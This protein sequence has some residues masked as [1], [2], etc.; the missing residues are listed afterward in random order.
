M[1]YVRI[2]EG[3]WDWSHLGGGF[4]HFY[5]H[6]YLGRWSTLT[7]IFQMSWNHQPD[8]GLTFIYGIKI[9]W[10]S[11]LS[12]AVTCVWNVKSYLWN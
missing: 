2:P 4:K 6:P 11:W 5:F 12:D 10:W 8:M 1:A 3:K 9:T 7:N